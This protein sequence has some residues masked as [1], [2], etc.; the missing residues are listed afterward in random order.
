MSQTKYKPVQGSI[1]DPLYQMSD[2]QRRRLQNSWAADFKMHILPVLISAEDIF[3]PLYS[4]T[5]NSRPS[6]P[7]YLVLGLLVLKSLFGLTDE[8]LEDR[9]AFS[10]DFQ[11]ALETTSFTRQPINQRTLNRFRAANALYTQETHIDLMAQFFDKLANSLKDT[12][13]GTNLKRRM[14]SIMIDNGCRKLSR[15]QLAHVV[16]K[17][18]LFV[19]DEQTVSIPEALHHYIEDFDENAVTYH[20]SQPAAQKLEATF[21]DA[22]TVRNLFPKSLQACDEFQQLSRFISEQVILS[23]D[24]EFEAIRDGK[25]LTSTTLNNPA[26]PES[27]IRKKAGKVYQGYVGNFAETV[28]L[29]TDRKIIDSVDFQPNIYSDVKFAKDEIRKMAEN[30]DRTPVVADG[31][32]IS[33]ETVKLAASHGIELTGTAMTGKD[34]PDLMA[35]FSIDEDEQTVIC[36][37]GKAADRA[38]YSEKSESWRVSYHLDSTC[39]GCPF[40]GSGECPLKKRKHV[41]SGIISQ[42]KI[43]RAQMQR[44]MSGAEF[45]ENYRFRNGVEAIP[46]QLRRNQKIDHLPFRG[47]LRKKHGYILAIA[48]VNIRRALRYI[49]EDIKNLPEQLLPCLFNIVFVIFNRYSQALGNPY[50]KSV[51]LR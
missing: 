38:T 6:T 39:R 48:A 30:E 33:D 9:L 10:I 29:D 17:N 51:C 12:F 36:P 46:S 49:R 2:R 50:R 44:Q 25:E 31:G 7:T 37:N 41:C 13:L 24:G 18:A 43:D 11:Y 47:L 26:E 3:A 42:K 4:S 20:S 32:Y 35:E 23:A 34:T 16:T 8:E 28:D 5:P 22:C 40:L 27:T 19:L 14:D 21:R 1:Y 45:K 15:L